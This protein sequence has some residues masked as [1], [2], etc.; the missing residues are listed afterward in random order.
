MMN[1]RNANW[2]QRAEGWGSFDFRPKRYKMYHQLLWL[3]AWLSPYAWCPSIHWLNSFDSFIHWYS[4]FLST[5]NFRFALSLRFSESLSHFHPNYSFSFPLTILNGH[6]SGT[7][8]TSI[9]PWQRQRQFKW[10]EMKFKK[11]FFYFISFILSI[12]IDIFFST[13]TTWI[14]ITTQWNDVMIY[15]MT[16]IF[17]MM[18]RLYS[19]IL[20]LVEL[21]L[22]MMMWDDYDDREFWWWWIKLQNVKVY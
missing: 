20:N 6:V 4:S 22:I 11:N 9:I 8:Y 18:M 14:W 5:W 7:S 17:I 16:N 21:K 1:M 15:K 10:N 13:W 2:D 12:F 3:F 19:V